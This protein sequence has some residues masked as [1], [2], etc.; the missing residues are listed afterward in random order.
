MYVTP[1][2][3]NRTEA[4]DESELEAKRLSHEVARF[5]KEREATAAAITSMETAHA[6]I[7]DQRQCVV[8]AGGGSW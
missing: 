7:L 3:S 1:T 8:V 5:H 4:R 2:V 6:W